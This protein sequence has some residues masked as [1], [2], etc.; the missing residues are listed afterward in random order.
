MGLHHRD[1]R[2][3]DICIEG[4]LGPTNGQ[5]EIPSISHSTCRSQVT[6]SLI[7]LDLDCNNSSSTPPHHSFIQPV[8]Y[9]M[10]GTSA[11]SVPSNVIL[12]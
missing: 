7:T 3:L 8:S 10:R 6:I 12:N 4:S 1:E 2:D 11:F 5:A 9:G